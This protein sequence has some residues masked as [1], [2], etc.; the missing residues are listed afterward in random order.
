MTTGQCREKPIGSYELQN[1]L[2]NLLHGTAIKRL[3]SYKCKYLSKMR[4]LRIISTVKLP[5]IWLTGAT[6]ARRNITFNADL[7]LLKYKDFGRCF[8]LV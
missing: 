8:P 6:V 5:L 1:L 4:T 3:Q 7:I 2:A